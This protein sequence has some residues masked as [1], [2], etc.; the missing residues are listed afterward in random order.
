M[1]LIENLI[2]RWKI[3]SK[4]KINSKIFLNQFF[5]KKGLQ[6]K[7]HEDTLQNF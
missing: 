6:L 7:R 2:G 1:Q 4:T 5:R 3:N